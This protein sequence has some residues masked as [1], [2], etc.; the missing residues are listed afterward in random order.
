MGPYIERS[1]LPFSAQSFNS[2]AQGPNTIAEAVECF[3]GLAQPAKLHRREIVSFEPKTKVALTHPRSLSP[4]NRFAT[5]T[6]S[7]L[8]HPQTHT[9][10][11]TGGKHPTA[12]CDVGYGV[13]CCVGAAAKRFAPRRRCGA[14]QSRR[15][16]LHT[17]SRRSGSPVSL[18]QCR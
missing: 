1:S 16:Q 18:R 3:E 8:P 4:A 9:S 6:I 12:L 14:E 10:S 11:Y 15:V 2:I 7:P 17:Q 13:R 5:S